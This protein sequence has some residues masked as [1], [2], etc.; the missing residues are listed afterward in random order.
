MFDDKDKD[1]AE[2][3]WKEIAAQAF[4]E[5]AVVFFFFGLLFVIDSFFK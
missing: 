3:A 4:F 2:T 5:F 1:E